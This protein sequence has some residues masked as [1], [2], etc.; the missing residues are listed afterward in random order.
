L[1]K[2]I[3]VSDGTGFVTYGN[4]LENKSVGTEQYGSWI[5]KISNTGD[6]LW[7]RYYTFFDGHD[8]APEPT[9]FKATPDGGYVVSGQTREGLLNFGW[10]MKLDSFGC[11]IP[12]CQWQDTVTVSGQPGKVAAE[13]AIYPNPTSDYL[14]FQLRSPQAIP[15]A[16]FR[17]LDAQG[18]VVKEFQ[19]EHPGD[20]VIV[21]V[22]DWAPGVYFLEASAEGRVLKTEKFVVMK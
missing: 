10:L 20:T 6:S 15:Q 13:L 19:S 18:R 22:W 17:I 8:R 11:L 9:D 4:L 14:N 1:F 12:G 2:I 5:V 7:A 3:P 21:P 16:A